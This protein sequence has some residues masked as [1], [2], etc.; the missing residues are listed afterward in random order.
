M[1]FV[2]RLTN[3]ILKRD[4]NIIDGPVHKHAYSS[5]GKR[6]RVE[7]AHVSFH[8]DRSR[9]EWTTQHVTL[10]GP[11]LRKDGTEGKETFSGDPGYGWE[12][13]PEYAWLVKM[14][15]AIRPEGVPELPFRLAGLENDETE[16]I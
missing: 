10:R 13:R 15:D 4:V 11:V 8:L 2:H 1:E 6:Y 16:E 5:T 12:R 3:G 14:I 9:G 7:G